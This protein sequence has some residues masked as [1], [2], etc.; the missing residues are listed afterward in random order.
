MSARVTRKKSIKFSKWAIFSLF[1]CLCGLALVLGTRGVRALWQEA[2]DVPPGDNLPG[3][4]NAGI[5]DQAKRGK[6]RIGGTGLP[7][8]NL[9]VQGGAYV[10]A[11]TVDNDFKVMSNTLYVNS[12]NDNVGIGTAS[13]VTKLDI[14][15]TGTLGGLKIGSNG[16]SCPP[17]PLRCR[18]L[19]VWSSNDYGV[20]AKGTTGGVQ[21]INDNASG[22]GVR[23]QD[24]S[25][26]GGYGVY[27]ESATGSGV[28]GKSD[29]G[30]AVYAENPSSTAWA[31]YFTGRVFSS[32]DV[33]GTRFLPEKLQASLV[34][35]TQGQVMSTK[36][37]YE[38]FDPY[39]IA[40]DDDNFWVVRYGYQDAGGVVY[41]IRPSDGARIAD[42]NLQQHGPTRVIYDGSNYI[43]VTNWD[44]RTLS[45]LNKADGSAIGHYSTV[46]PGVNCDDPNGQENTYYEGCGPIDLVFDG[47]Y[48][49]TANYYDPDPYNSNLGTSSISKIQAS[50]GAF[51][52]TYLM[53]D[54]LGVNPNSITFDGTNIWT[55]NVGI[56]GGR[57][58][59]AGPATSADSVSKFDSVTNTFS[60][61]SIGSGTKPA[62]IIYDGVANLWT[63]NFGTATVS[64][65][66]PADGTVVQTSATGEQGTQ[67]VMVD[68][69][70]QGGPYIWA[71]NGSSVTKFDLA[72]NFILRT[73]P[74][75]VGVTGLA[76]EK[77]YQTGGNNYTYIWTTD[78]SYDQLSKVKSSDGTI[79]AH[80]LPGGTVR[81]NFAFDGTYIWTANSYNRSISK[82]RAADG[83]KIADYFLIKDPAELYN[84][85][86][87]LVY[88]G[89]YIW[90]IHFTYSATYIS[91]I[92]ASDGHVEILYDLLSNTKSPVD[93]VLDNNTAGGPYLWILL[94]GY[95]A[96]E[97]SRLI[98]YRI[99]ENKVVFNQALGMNIPANSQKPKAM[100][101]DGKNLW[102]ANYYDEN[103][104][105]S[106][107]DAFSI[108]KV[109]LDPLAVS[110]P[111]NL[112]GT[113]KPSDILFDGKYLWTVNAGN[114][115][116]GVSDGSVSKWLINS[117]GSVTQVV[118]SPF[119]VN[120]N[121]EQPL[122]L[123]FDGTDIW[124]AANPRFGT[125]DDTYVTTLRASD[126]QD[127][128]SYYL[129]NWQEVRAIAFDGSSVW[130][131]STDSGL[132]KFYSGAGYGQQN[133]EQV[134]R[135]QNVAPGYTDGEGSNFKHFNISGSG[136]VGDEAVVGANVSVTNNVWGTEISG[137][138]IE[139]NQWQKTGDI[140]GGPKSPYNT[141]SLLEASDGALYAGVSYNGRVYK[142]TDRGDNWID[143]GQLP[144]VNS[145]DNVWVWDLLQRSDGSI[146]VAY[147]IERA[148]GSTDCTTGRIAWSDNGGASWQVV[149]DFDCYCKEAGGAL[150]SNDSECTGVT[151]TKTVEHVYSLL[152][153][154]GGANQGL[155]AGIYSSGWGGGLHNKI[156]KSADGFNWNYTADLPA[157]AGGIYT[158]LEASDGYLYVASNSNNYISKTNDGGNSWVAA[159]AISGIGGVYTLLEASNGYIYAGTGG[160][161]GDVF[162]SN[163]GGN[164][165]AN[166]GNLSGANRV[167]SLI[168]MNGVLY[169]SADDTIDPKDGKVFRS[170]N[171]GDSW[172]EMGDLAGAQTVDPLLEAR[173]GTIYAGATLSPTWAAVFR[174][175]PLP[176]GVHNCPDGH[177][178]K[179]I[180][181]NGSGQVM[182]VECRPL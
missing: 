73:N 171:G 170:D 119:A 160:T 96:G 65:I 23:G 149:K 55:A 39:D 145:S 11:L 3:F 101:F 178:V 100:A 108:L 89:Q 50:N 156:I 126:G 181:V 135:L 122:Y 105:T 90:V 118:G 40:F 22:I 13:P 4:L 37:N 86:A 53:Q 82:I 91:K 113:Y 75:G 83:Q 31:G 112:T 88:D 14:E 77:T 150:C 24:N 81:T 58:W 47:T 167:K 127:K 107:N 180:K 68:T 182:K 34:P 152:D 114:F 62:D 72:G 94:A 19:S 95:S 128:K 60:T 27:A 133:I 16:V 159:T 97:E 163:D 146:Y 142:S 44:S 25:T 98:G 179:D 154:Q 148:G 42:I 158:L 71:S 99:S 155:Y 26:S 139:S 10:D 168:E 79:E 21:G 93:I 162:R 32:L 103:N 131:S 129:A 15:G 164:N 41:K 169:A 165:W 177:F 80:Y 29:T 49:W 120:T 67:R 70:T 66:N 141:L 54:P 176:A 125:N 84:R 161:N 33:V 43:W 111:I 20:W 144:V 18:A 56:P 35:F 8:F 102:I 69:I 74:T 116:D 157:G 138:I 175:S 59:Y 172:T 115:I 12:N 117:D 137:D 104:R 147:G 2:T 7:G 38:M 110:S 78:F 46:K 143:L 106:A 17:S 87:Q 85:P 48:I 63:A 124:V 6:L 61:Y 109:Q 9:E 57:W 36:N 140:P 76:T 30:Y 45:K 130:L 136:I 92:R 121:G 134:V 5:D 28:Y 174:L 151:C 1:F 173:D 64:K 123:T 51:M 52:G 153:I 166:T 132:Y